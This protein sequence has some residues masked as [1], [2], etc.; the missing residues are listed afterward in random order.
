M[1]DRPIL[2]GLL[3]WATIIIY[4]FAFLTVLVV[5]DR[6]S[7]A[8]LAAREGVPLDMIRGGLII[9]SAALIAAGMGILRGLDWSR[10]VFVGVHV[11]DALIDY[12]LGV[13]TRIGPV[14]AV[15]V[16]ATTIY[17]FRPAA[18]EWFTE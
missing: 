17:L 9:E 10:Y 12:I 7:F 15:L 4:G 14:G 3:G 5:W 2:M 1:I 16:I 13:H 18:D 8:M 6:P 11:A